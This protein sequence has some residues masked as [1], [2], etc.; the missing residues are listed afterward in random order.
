MRTFTGEVL[1]DREALRAETVHSIAAQARLTNK[2]RSTLIGGDSALIIV[3]WNLEGDVAGRHPHLADRNDDGRRPP[4]GRRVVA[5]RRPQ[6]SRDGW[7]SRV[8][9]VAS[10]G[11]TPRPAVASVSPLL[12]P[13]VTTGRCGCGI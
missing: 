4:V 8:V 9:V 3:D 2:P 11:A 5:V 13:W 7:I 12:S 6:L 10:G 1:T